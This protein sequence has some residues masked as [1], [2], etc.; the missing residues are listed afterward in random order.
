MFMT[1]YGKGSMGVCVG[2]GGKLGRAEAGEVSS[3][4]TQIQETD[5]ANVNTC[6]MTNEA[7]KKKKADEA[8]CPHIQEF[9]AI[10]NQGIVPQGKQDVWSGRGTKRACVC[11]GKRGSIN[12]K[13]VTLNA[14][15]R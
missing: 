2:E 6:N 12:G 1:E 10:T 7:D 8:A 13:R 5:S 14:S 4:L 9:I 3:I 11:T 15:R